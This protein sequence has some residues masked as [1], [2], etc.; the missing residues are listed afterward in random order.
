MLSSSM[1][2]L[3]KP[4][5]L[6][7]TKW[8]KSWKQ[9]TTIVSLIIFPHNLPYRDPTNISTLLVCLNLSHLSFFWCL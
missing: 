2:S 1:I 9:C 4:S 8:Q 6:H 7:N 3:Q 5:S